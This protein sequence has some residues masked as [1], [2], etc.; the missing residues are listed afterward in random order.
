MGKASFNITKLTPNTDIHTQRLND[1]SCAII[2]NSTNNYFKKFYEY[3]D[4]LAKA[5]KKYKETI[6]QNMQ[7]SAILNIFQEAIIS[8]DNRHKED[9]IID[10]FFELNQKFGG[11]Q[12]INLAIH[13]DEGYF[14]KDTINY[15]PH[16]N[17]LK[18]GD[19]WFITE[20]GNNGKTNED[21]KILVNINEFNK[22]LTPHAHAIFSMFDF[23]LGRNAR[24]QKKDMVERLK[25]VAEILKMEYAP[26]KIYEVLSNSVMEENLKNLD[27][28]IKTKR[29]VLF[30]INTQISFKESELEELNTSLAEQTHILN[31]TLNKIQQR[32]KDLKDLVAQIITKEDIIDSLN[33]VITSK[34]TNVTSLK[35]QIQQ[36]EFTL[37]E[38]NKKINENKNIAI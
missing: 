1:F 4:F 23:A 36:K 30:D 17:I 27:I 25:F 14:Q 16:K 9:D 3:E 19:K 31:D 15:Y 20:N 21:F 7:K 28:Q 29:Q 35:A 18:K 26:K 2:Q 33:H 37:E 12:L 38:L 22:V 24:M 8:I 11:H 6:K 10:L 34:S 32:D 5:Q 13:K